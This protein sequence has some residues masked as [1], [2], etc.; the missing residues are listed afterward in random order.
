MSSNDFLVDA[1]V[2]HQI[3][4]QRYA[5]GQVKEL[6]K[7]LT[8]MADDLELKVAQAA[9]MSEAKKLGTQLEE[10]RRII[11]DGLESM[12]SGLLKSSDDLAE[13]E[14]EFAVRTITTAATIDATLPDSALLRAIVTDKP[15]QLQ[16]G[17]AV[18]E[19]T[20]DRAV[21]T[22]SKKKATE[23]KR[24]I[25]TGFINGTPTG[26]LVSQLRSTTGR[27]KRE[28][29]ALIRTTTAHI[30][31]EARQEIHMANAD[32]MAGEKFVA[33]LDSRTTIV[34]GLN[35]GKIFPVGKGTPAPRHWQ[36]RSVRVPVLKPEYQIAGFEGT[37]ASKGSSFTGQVSAKTTYEGWLK[38]QS[39][40]FQDEAL[41]RERAQLFR[42]GGLSLDKFVDDSGVTYT[43]ERLR[44]LEKLAFER[45]GL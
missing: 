35:D 9:T 27:L 18:Q 19:L 10:I 32:I 12:Q 37:R 24:I 44:E 29:E 11:D 2:R 39:A 23:V 5:G 36:C 20:I 14:G 28:A 1:G 26:Q 17:K 4:V 6:V 31:S 7:Y 22:F 8:D 15:M 13:Y 33:T 41:G 25:Q 30:S 38:R 21:G 45:A 34:C 42:R 16:A 43:L 3:F 40:S